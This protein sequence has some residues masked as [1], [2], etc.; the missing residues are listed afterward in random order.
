M[1]SWVRALPDATVR[2]SPVLAIMSAWS[3]LMAGDLDADE[4]PARRRR[5]R[6]GRRRSRPR[7]RWRR[8]G[9]TP[10]I[11]APLPAMILVYRASIAQARGDV[12]GTAHTPGAPSTGRPGRPLRPRRRGRVR[13][14]AAWAAGDVAEALDTFTEAVREPA[15]GRSLVDELGGTVVLADM[16]LAAGDRARP[17]GST[18]G[19]RHRDLRAESYPGRPR[20]CTSGLAEI[21]LERATSARRAAPRDRARARRAGVDH[22]E[23]APLVRRGPA[24][25]R[26]GDLD[27]AAGLLDQARRST[28]PGF[29]PD[30]RPLATKARAR[31]AQGDLAEAE[32]WARERGVHVTDEPTYLREYDHLTLVRLLVAQHDSGA[33][34]GRTDVDAVLGRSTA[35]GRRRRAR[36]PARD[37]A[38]R[39]LVHHAR[40]RR[41]PGARGLDLA[42]R[43]HPGPEGYA[44]LFLDEGDPML[45]LLGATARSARGV[46]LARRRSR[47]RAPARRAGPPRTG[48][49]LDLGRA[50]STVRGPAQRARARGAA[51]ARQRAD[52]AGDRPAAV[53]HAQHAAHPH[54]AHLHQARRHHRRAAVRRGREPSALL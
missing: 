37:R 53:R 50:T 26:R 46:G 49:G 21:D 43:G 11:S 32:A 1:L 8:P 25:R 31:I 2:R 12:A 15:R 33:L 18:S 20:T 3:L 19:A 48:A 13:R 45:E 9:W 47:R 17:A 38:D 30:V 24:A 52:R 23:P 27:A 10:R 36:E 28:C 14:P 16:W 6:A 54:Q 51:A 35:A 29:F 44:R 34:S 4:S 5:A 7:A 42:W 41:G 22:R 39:G 40:R